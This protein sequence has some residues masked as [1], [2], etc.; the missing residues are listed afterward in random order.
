M[1]EKAKLADGT[2]QQLYGHYLQI[3]QSNFYWNV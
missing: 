1:P 2:K 3:I